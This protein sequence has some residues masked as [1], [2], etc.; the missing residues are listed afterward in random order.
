M[1]FSVWYRFVLAVYKMQ[2][3]DSNHPVRLWERS[4]YLWCPS[5]CI[6][7]FTECIGEWARRLGLFDRLQYSHW[8]GQPSGNSLQSLLCGCYTVGS[9]LFVVKQVLSNLLQYVMVDGYQSKLVTVVSELP[10]GSVLDP[11]F[12]TCTPYSFSPYYRIILTVMLTTPLW[13]CASH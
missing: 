1:C 3:C 2:R 6:S 4:W 8:Q 11:Q 13:I 10:P 12:S 7:H 5:V 9:V